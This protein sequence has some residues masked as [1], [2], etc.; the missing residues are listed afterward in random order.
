MGDTSLGVDITEFGSRLIIAQSWFI[1]SELIRRHPELRLIETNPLTGQYNCLTIVAQRDREPRKIIDLN[2]NG[3][4]KA[5]GTGALVAEPI[6]WS[7]TLSSFAASQATPSRGHN[8]LKRL[9]RDAG[10]TAPATTPA[11]SPAALS[12]RVIARVLSGLLNDKAVWDARNE[13]EDTDG[14]SEIYKATG[15]NLT[16]TIAQALGPILP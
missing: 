6:P 7:E 2:R 9:E 16:L 11:S 12:Y 5:Y 3:R 13:R 4:M 8:A 14:W 1:A 10:L 15:H